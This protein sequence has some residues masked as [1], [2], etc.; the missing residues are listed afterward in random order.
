M[1]VGDIYSEVAQ[2][3]FETQID[4]GAVRFYQVLN[5]CLRQANRIAPV[6]KHLRIALYRSKNLLEKTPR[7]IHNTSDD[8]VYEAAGAKA[9]S[10]ELFGNGTYGIQY[11]DDG[12]W[13]NTDVWNKKFDYGVGYRTIKEKVTVSDEYVSST[14]PVRVVFS[15]DSLFI[16]QNVGMYDVLIGDDKKNVP[17]EAPYVE[18]DM[19][20]LVDDFG[21]FKTAPTVDGIGLLQ[22]EY[23]VRG[24]SYILFHKSVCGTADVEYYHRPAYVRYNAETLYGE[25]PRADANEIDAT[26]EVCEILPYLVASYMWLDDD[27]DKAQY[28]KA[29]YEER[30]AEIMS[31]AKVTTPIAIQHNGW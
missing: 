18:Y 19:H 14:V 22:H 8:I 9:C 3:G 12:T 23:A 20:D 1:T 4:D 24:T 16:V 26:D 29:M 30:A 27:P 6:V 15:G 17:T 31:R 28:Y 7:K 2:L 11:Y 5:R 10:F 21:G 25:D 13:K